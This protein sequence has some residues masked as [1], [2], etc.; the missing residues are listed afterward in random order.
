[1]IRDVIKSLIAIKQQEIPFDIIDRDVKLPMNRRKSITI[2]GV[3]Q[4]GKSMIM[5]IAINKL[6][7]Q[8][9]F[10]CMNFYR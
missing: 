2:P 10:G 6:V 3:R 7:G 5:E 9:M 8:G 4:C 1:M